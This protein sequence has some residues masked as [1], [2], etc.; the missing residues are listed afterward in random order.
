VSV[1]SLTATEILGA[2]THAKEATFLWSAG[3]DSLEWA[4]NPA[5]ILRLPDIGTPTSGQA[6]SDLFSAGDM[7]AR[8]AWLSNQSRNEPF[9]GTYRITGP[10][11]QSWVEERLVALAD[12]E[13]GQRR[14]LGRLRNVS[15]D[16]ENFEKL[17]YLARFDEL[18]GHLSRSHLR[19][20]LARRMTD[21]DRDGKA[22]CFGLIG[23][24]NLAGFNNMFGYDIADVVLTRIGEA[25]AAHTGPDDVIGRIG[26]SKFAI[27]FADCPKHALHDRLA[28][29]QAGIREGIIDTGAGPVAV[30]VSAAGL[31]V[32]D[33]ATTTHD[34]FAVAED[35]LNGAKA[36]GMDQ[37]MIHTPDASATT[38]R[39][40]NIAVADDII[41][42]MHE[43]R[44]CLAYQ[45][46][47]Q[48]RNPQEVAFHEC[49]LRL[50]DRSGNLVNAGAFMPVAEKLGLVRLLDRRV[51][52]LAFD[53][54][55]RNPNVRLSVNVSPQSLRDASWQEQFESLAAAHPRVLDRLILEMT[56]ATVIEDAAEAATRLNRFRDMGCAVA[57][58]DF[59]AGYTSFQQLRDLTIDI[60]KIDGTYI[61]NILDNP[62]DQVFVEALCGIARH[63]DLLIVAEMVDSDEAGALLSKLG[64]DTFQ[65]FHYGRPDIEPDWLVGGPQARVASA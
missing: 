17:S 37:V 41:A 47:V 21:A 53:T 1:S 11:G 27:L 25:I 59:G 6:W 34:V 57:L 51:I 5:E 42:A 16:R 22:I 28:E 46:I 36:R 65:G 43:N 49:L 50:I 7:E 33:D 14:Y 55:C 58:D 26:S 4:S 54:L 48:A 30:T 9:V 39:E 10:N 12:Q 23:L 61:R 63:H 56:E 18:T 60:V 2:L 8:E 40:G 32:P 35:T 13:T 45:P 20:V 24:D 31:S 29:I 3:N 52:E 19:A 64:V 62:D 15:A 44:L 38:A